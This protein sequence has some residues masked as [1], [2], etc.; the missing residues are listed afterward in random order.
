[1]DRRQ[2][3]ATTG[4]GLVGFGAVQSVSAQKTPTPPKFLLS[5]LFRKV[6]ADFIYD[7]L[8]RKNQIR[9]KPGS[10][11]LVSKSYNSDIEEACLDVLISAA[12]QNNSTYYDVQGERGVLTKRLVML[13]SQGFERLNNGKGFMGTLLVDENLKF[14]VSHDEIVPLKDVSNLRVYGAWIRPFDFNSYSG[15]KFGVGSKL[16]M[17][18]AVSKCGLFNTG[19]SVAAMT[20]YVLGGVA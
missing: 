1:M 14:Q 5:S 10:V 7:E 9:T 16:G 17:C 6:D 4:A 13:M 12:I 15:L 18:V 2:F 8:W 20:D 19:N 3:L 11:S